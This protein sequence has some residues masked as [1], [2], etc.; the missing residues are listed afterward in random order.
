M[1]ECGTGWFVNKGQHDSA[2]SGMVGSV[3]ALEHDKLTDSVHAY[4]ANQ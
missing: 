3:H 2:Y 1:A 4:D